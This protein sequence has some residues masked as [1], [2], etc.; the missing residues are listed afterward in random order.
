MSDLGFAVSD[1]MRSF[2]AR[3]GVLAVEI[4]VRIVDELLTAYGARLRTVGA[5]GGAIGSAS[6]S[7]GDAIASTVLAI[8]ER[9]DAIRISIAFSAHARGRSTILVD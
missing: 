1:A 5:S 9:C 7:S 8:S 4:D 2:R 6:A 3:V